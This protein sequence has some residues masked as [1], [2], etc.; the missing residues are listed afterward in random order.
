[1]PTPHIKG[2]EVTE[3][4]DEP[5]RH[6]FAPAASAACPR[7]AS[8]SLTWT[9]WLVESFP[10]W[11]CACGATGRPSPCSE[12]QLVEVPPPALVRRSGLPQSTDSHSAGEQP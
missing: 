7:C 10:R 6:G 4:F 9:N 2:I 8:T 5:A 12:S 3:H 11:Y 1:M